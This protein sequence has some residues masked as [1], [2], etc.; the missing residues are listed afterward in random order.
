MG[1]GRREAA[2]EVEKVEVGA[3]TLKR[4]LLAD[5]ERTAPAPSP[6]GSSSRRVALTRAIGGAAF[7]YLAHRAWPRVRQDGG[8]VLRALK[9]G[10]GGLNP[11]K[12]RRG[13]GGRRGRRRGASGDAALDAG[14]EGGNSSRDEAVDKISRSAARRDGRE[15]DDASPPGTTRELPVAVS[16]SSKSIAALRALEEDARRPLFDDPFAAALAGPEAV[17]RVRSNGGDK[18]RIAIRT[19]FFDDAVL[20]AIEGGGD[21]RGGAP[22]EWQ[23]VLLG[24]GLDTRAW[25]LAPRSRRDGID[26]RCRAVF[27]VDV[28]EVLGHKAS[29][30]A[31]TFGTDF[32]L[33]LA[34]THA[35][36]AANVAKRDWLARL[37]DAGHDFARPTVWVLEGLLYYLSQE[38]CQEVLRQCAGASAPGSRLVASAVNGAS[39]ARAR[40]RGKRG[41][42][43]ATWAS[44]IDEPVEPFLR[45]L[46]WT[47][48]A[49]R[50]PGESGCEYGRWRGEPPPPRDPEERP[51]DA[52]PRTWYVTAEVSRSNLAGGATRSVQTRAARSRD[53]SR[54]SELWGSDARAFGRQ[55]REGGSE[56]PA[57]RRG[58]DDDYDGHFDNRD[59][60]RDDDDRDD[61]DDDDDGASGRAGKPPRRDRRIR[62]GAP[63]PPEGRRARES[64]EPRGEKPRLGKSSVGAMYRRRDSRDDEDDDDDEGPGRARERAPEP[65]ETSS[66]SGSD[67]P[68]D[69]SDSPRLSDARPEDAEVD[70]LQRRRCVER[71]YSSGAA[72]ARSSEG[73]R[74]STRQDSAFGSYGDIGAH[75]HVSRAHPHRKVGGEAIDSPSPS[76]VV[77][78]AAAAAAR[79]RE[80][81][82]DRERRRRAEE[83]SELRRRAREITERKRHQKEE[84]EERRKRVEAALAAAAARRGESGRI[85]G[86]VY[87]TDRAPTFAGS[88][89]SSD[90]P[91]PVVRS[92]RLDFRR[93]DRAFDAR[94]G[95]I[96]RDDDDLPNFGPTSLADAGFRLW[97]D[98]LREDWAALFPERTDR[99]SPRTSPT[100]STCVF[101]V[102]ERS[103]GTMIGVAGFHAV[104]ADAARAYLAVCVDRPHRRRGYARECWEA[105]AGFARSDLASRLGWVPTLCARVPIAN[106][107]AL[108]FVKDTRGFASPFSS[109]TGKG[110]NGGV[111]AQT[112][113]RRAVGTGGVR[114]VPGLKRSLDDPG[115]PV[116]GADREDVGTCQTF[117]L[118]ARDW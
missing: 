99:A 116:F 49:V 110:K 34:R 22:S 15:R 67:S 6:A 14:R 93:P 13:R 70:S 80:I 103:S 115:A 74:G 117:Y 84:E 4:R 28:P 64:P 48:R 11:L 41:G 62:P 98:G 78:V 81:E 95:E 118:D 37:S 76:K 68:R 19:R 3:R 43:K 100:P 114:R 79:L 92:D 65:A 109:P 9:R 108:F 57:G 96:L 47:T 73:I 94:A 42:A 101:D 87:G 102:F 82:A 30:M 38:A 53:E 20:D 90:G 105:V 60:D 75:T 88:T 29:V 112:F 61:G 18:G 36:V 89:S 12:G 97:R 33:S 26:G 17:A 39:L 45:R 77:S 44:A 7:V 24:A 25:R 63:K 58:R 8:R 69:G 85:S 66:S 31:E 107:P 91:G 51:E 111:H 16:D 72:S 46:G 55:T 40:A 104:D 2:R 83:E 1:F 56:R 50:Q 23:V 21:G 106:E 10:L 5:D 71:R 32:P 52:P 27:E 54:G 35:S 86:P 113:R 59:D